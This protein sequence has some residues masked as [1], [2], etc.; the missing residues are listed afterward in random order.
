MSGNGQ[1]ITGRQIRR[2]WT[3]LVLT[4]LL[5]ALA[6]PVLNAAIGRAADPT[7]EL[8]G[9]WVAFTVM[10]FVQS[11]SLVIQQVTVALADS[12]ET[13]RRLA[14]SAL[15]LGLV[16]SLALLVIAWTPLGAFVFQAVIP[17]TPRVAELA[18][19]VLALLIPVPTLIAI[20]DLGA[21]LAIREHRTRLVAISTMVRLV[22]LAAVVATVGTIGPGPGA[23]AGAAA[24][25][26]GIA[27]EAAFILAAT[28]RTWGPR[29]RDHD[30]ASSAVPYGGILRVALPLAVATFVWTAVRPVLSAI[31]GR[32]PDSE[33][34]QASF[35][36]VLPILMVT[37]SP[38]WGFHNVSL[39]LPRD[40]DDLRRVIGSAAW[41]TLVFALGI[42]LVTLTP[43]RSLVLRL[44]FDLSPAMERAV[45]P[46]LGW[47]TLAPLFLTA[48]ALAQGLLVRSR[49]TGVM[50]IVSP[51]KLLLMIAV[52]TAVVS[53]APHANGAALA[54][55]LIIGG[56]LFDALILGL[57]VHRL[58]ARG[59]LFRESPRAVP[60]AETPASGMPWALPSPSLENNG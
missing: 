34:A 28:H 45:V 1:A 53:R 51:I 8:A 10:L 17:T 43:L 31:L 9:F 44:G 60:L 6:G 23:R 57:L 5:M 11:A 18:R 37:C 33:L 7:L 36:I 38:L 24:F 26:I 21:G 46:A 54:I 48:R 20:R 59:L 56:D 4:S 30:R 35:G 29:L 42:G 58:I 49:R 13:L 12:G 25:V 32:L 2:F 22:A 14:V 3:P 40:R 27:I 39:V 47:M 50:L 41:I 19:T 52:G 55:L 15:L 16:A